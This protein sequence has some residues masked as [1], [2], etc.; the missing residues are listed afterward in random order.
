MSL[1]ETVR[2]SKSSLVGWRSGDQEGEPEEGKEII[3]PVCEEVEEVGEEDEEFG[4]IKPTTLSSPYTPSRQERIEHELTHLPFRSW[5]AH[6]V[7]GKSTSM[8]HRHKDDEEE[9]RVPTVGID[10]AFI[11]KSAVDE[12][13]E[14]GEVTVMVAKDSRS[15][16]V[17]PVPVP[18]KGIDSEEYA[19]RQLLKI[20]DFMGL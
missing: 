11:K 16:A 8:H 9:K 14:M 19:C 13:H 15:K 7:R 20:L 6:C 5:C 12:E 17:F 2:P 1:G 10:Y 3:C 4:L 18:R